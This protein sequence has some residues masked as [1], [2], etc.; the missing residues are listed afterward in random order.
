[1][2]NFSKQFRSA[3]AAVILAGLL[4]APV[5]FAKGHGGG[6]HGGGSRSFGG[7]M[8]GKNF[9]NTKSFSGGN[10]SFR[11]NSGNNKVVPFKNG[12]T[13]FT[14]IGKPHN[15]LQTLSNSTQ[16]Q[17]ISRLKTSNVLR[18]QGK[19][20]DVLSNGPALGGAH[21]TS[22][23][24]FNGNLGNVLGMPG[25]GGGMGNGGGKGNGNGMGGKWSHNCHW[26]SNF[27]FPGYAPY[28][29]PTPG[30]Y[31]CGPTVIY[32]TVPQP[33]VVEVPPAY[34][35]TTSPV[36]PASATEPVST[37]PSATPTTQ[38]VDLVLD[39]I[40]LAEPATLV[41]G[42][43]YRVKFRNQGTMA[44]GAFRVG[45]VAG[46]EDRPI[47][48]SPRAVAD[49]PGLG[50][51]QTGEVQL[52][53]PLGSMKLIGASTVSSKEFSFLAGA[54]DVDEAV[55]ESDKTNNVASVARSEVQPEDSV[56]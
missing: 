27:F 52:Q 3:V 5:A 2:S 17:S 15:S 22:L 40:E 51:S 18:H 34:P 31:A 39:T 50:A 20:A 1:M 4:P 38:G 23:K 14:G 7:S 6:G 26:P 35:T 16:S 24:K 55:S 21:G 9:S 43:V 41:G 54:V 32:Q 25:Q 33:V 30:S 46:F 37:P 56:H 13:G 28:Y 42:P 36:Q 8:S 53:L 29:W 47:E 12:N 44:A 48:E 19:N 11:F 49:V 10:N 45:L